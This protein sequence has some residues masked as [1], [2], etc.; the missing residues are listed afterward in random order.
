LTTKLPPQSIDAETSVLGAILKD[1][2]TFP[3]LQFLEPQDFYK[4]AHQLIF[5]ACQDAFNL[6]Q[7]TDIITITDILKNTH[8]LERAGG[9]YYITGLPEQCVSTHL[10]KDHA[11]KIKE[12]ALLRKLQTINIDFAQTPQHNLNESLTSIQSKIQHLIDE[13]PANG[14][15]PGLK[16]N[17]LQEY[18]EDQSPYPEMIIKRGILPKKSIIIIGGQPKSYK[19]I[20][21]LNIAWQIATGQKWL[22]FTIAEP[23]KVLILQSENSYDNQR[24]R[25]HTLMKAT[26]TPYK[27]ESPQKGMLILSQP[28]SLKINENND[29]LKLQ[30]LI[31][32]ENPDVVII[33]PFV[34][35]HSLNENDN[36]EMSRIMRRLRQIVNDLDISIIIIHHERKPGIR[37]DETGTGLRGASAIFGACDSVITITREKTKATQKI[38]YYLDFDV[39]NDEPI[40]RMYLELDHEVLWFMKTDRKISQTID[41][42]IIDALIE[43]KENGIKQTDLQNTGKQ[44]GFAE[45]TIRNNIAILIKKGTIKTNEKQRGRMLWYHTFYQQIPF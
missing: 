1:P 7:P 20:L 42:W 41:Q 10:A 18:A 23:S 36:A 26:E 33:D 45:R 27:L 28:F 39:R 38:E 34:D 25:I 24:R 17:D 13:V 5:K 21:S 4:Q 12:T 32:L 6:N 37:K 16:L 15:I 43:K 3:Q 44:L 19:S 22:D 35:F 14:Y 40:D 29:Y 11:Q 30:N 31:K 2:D 8:K 9:A